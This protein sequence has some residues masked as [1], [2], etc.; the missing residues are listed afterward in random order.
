MK[1][2]GYYLTLLVVA[3][4]LLSVLQPV[5]GARTSLWNF[6]TVKTWLQ[7]DFDGTGLTSNGTVLPTISTR[8]TSLPA[9]MAW[10]SEPHGETKLIGTSF[11]SAV[12]SVDS[13]GNYTLLQKTEDLGFTALTKTNG[14]VYAAATPSGR[15]YRYDSAGDGLTK[16]TT[17]SDSYVWTMVPDHSGNGLYI[18]TGPDGQLYHLSPDG[19]SSKIATIHGHNIMSLTRYNGKILL[20][21]DNG[22]VYRLK[23]DE[24][25]ESVYGFDGGEVSAMTGDETYLYVAVNQRTESKRKANQEQNISQ[26]AD[27][28]KQ[29]ALQLQQNQSMN[30]RDTASSFTDNMQSN[31]QRMMIQQ[32]RNQAQSEGSA[33]F[34]GLSGSLVYRMK[35]PEQMNIIY[36][37]RQEIVHDL[38]SDGTNLYV[39]TG[40]QGRLYKVKPDFT[41]IAYFKA[42]QKLVLDMNL[43]S[44]T[45]QTITT[46]EG[47]FVYDRTDFESGEA[48]YQSN[49]LDAH[50]LARW[51]Q[52]DTLGNG[53]YQIRTR[54]GNTPKPNDYWTDWSNWQNPSKFEIASSPARFFQF[55]LR[56]LKPDAQL[57]EL[58][59]AFQIPN[60]RPRITD[61]SITPNP[62]SQRFIETRE[63]IK[64]N[65]SSRQTSGAATGQSLSSLSVKERTVSWKIIDPDGDP[66]QNRLFYRPLDG[67]QWISFTG[68]NYI[69]ESQFSINLRNL[70]DGRYRL[71]L[72]ASDKR[73]ND[74]KYG[75]TTEKKTAPILVDNTQPN[76]QAVS[77]SP[78]AIQ[79]TAHDGVSRIMLAQYRINGEAWRTLSPEDGV[80]DESSE[81]FTFDLDPAVSSG[82]VIE[83]RLLDEGG[84][85]ALIRRT[86]P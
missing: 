84:N 2:I 23:E 52:L 60:Q 86:I 65:D 37:D 36:N 40:G 76:F 16:V 42:D 59:I 50:L 73:F 61:L 44:G 28:L 8:S 26:L 67:E 13:S 66:T 32:I 22:G 58:T 78:E 1:R 64:N 57:R 35:P 70:A 85:Q 12:Y 18:G 74:P 82:D 24:T 75:F 77:V 9:R 69:D 21:G 81:N 54:S 48:F 43:E 7:G 71:K 17:L 5:E 41:R 31:S 34:A 79:F 45:V 25:L 62:V 72:V 33:L 63:T 20:G 53:N 6:D 3:L 68:D 83:L 27:Q 80:F 39:A 51:G 29:E 11:P 4:G 47:G 19:E 30:T 15:I 46:G 10:E 56:F 49:V 38:A 14:S 55:E